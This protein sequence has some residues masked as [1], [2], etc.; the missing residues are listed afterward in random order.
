MLFTLENISAE[1]AGGSRGTRVELQ[2]K[3]LTYSTSNNPISGNQL[4][5]LNIVNQRGS[6]NLPLYVGFIGS[7]KVETTQKI[8]PPQDVSVTTTQQSNTTTISDRTY[9]STTEIPKLSGASSSE[10]SIENL[11]VVGS[12]RVLNDGAT[13]NTLILTFRYLNR[14]QNNKI[15]K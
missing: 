6:K 10:A 2:Y 1:P 12:N 13:E 7:T 14:L 8:T 11:N 15:K 5:Y 3:N 9:T 4:Q